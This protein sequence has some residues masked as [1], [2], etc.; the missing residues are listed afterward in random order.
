M[1]LCY[2]SCVRGGGDG[3][4]GAGTEVGTEW[5]DVHADWSSVC[6][7]DAGSE[8]NRLRKGSYCSQKNKR[9]LGSKCTNHLEKKE[10][11]KLP[12]L[13]MN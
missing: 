9:S 13:K 12:G 11:D 7:H 5:L 8:A 4:G 6:S 10:S 3:D 2:R 1:N